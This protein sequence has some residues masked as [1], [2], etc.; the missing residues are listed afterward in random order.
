MICIFY[1]AELV[2]NL[3]VLLCENLCRLVERHFILYIAATKKEKKRKER[4]TGKRCVYA[5]KE[6]HIRY[7]VPICSNFLLHHVLEIN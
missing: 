5:R 7:C 6:E 4:K 1:I 2:I 3:R